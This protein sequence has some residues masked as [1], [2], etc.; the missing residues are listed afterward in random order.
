MLGWGCAS[1]HPHMQLMNWSGW[2]GQGYRPYLGLDNEVEGKGRAGWVGTGYQPYFFPSQAAM[3]FL[4]IMASRWYLHSVVCYRLM[5][6]SSVSMLTADQS[7][8]TASY[9]EIYLAAEFHEKSNRHWVCPIHHLLE[10]SPERVQ[11][12]GSSQ[13][14]PVWHH[15]SSTPVRVEGQCSD[16]HSDV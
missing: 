5:T 3:M 13:G 10:E 15:A 7:K 9:H 6:S 4:T 1:P 12:N 2:W 16:Q 8:L 14:Q 11:A